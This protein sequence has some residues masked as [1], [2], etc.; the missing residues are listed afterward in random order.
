MRSSTGRDGHEVGTVFVAVAGPEG[1][2]VHNLRLSGDRWTIRRDT[3]RSA[4]SEP[5]RRVS[6]RGDV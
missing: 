1:T 3:V 2:Q 5:F 6:L 4:I